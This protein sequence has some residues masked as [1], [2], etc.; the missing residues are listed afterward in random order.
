MHTIADIVVSESATRSMLVV[1]PNV[2]ILNLMRWD[3]DYRAAINAASMRLNDSKVVRRIARFFQLDLP[4][5][6]GSDLTEVLLEKMR[7][8]EHK[9]VVVGS[10]PK[11]IDT[12][13][14][15][16]N[17]VLEGIHPPMRLAQN[18]ERRQ[19]LVSTLSTLEAHVILF[20][21]GSP[22]GE[23]VARDVFAVRTLPGTLIG[24]G[25]SIDFLSGTQRRAPMWFRDNSLE[26]LYRMLTNPGRLGPRYIT[27]F[28]GLLAMLVSEL[29]QRARAR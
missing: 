20:C 10:S 14:A 19:E 27:D 7:G 8:S 24:V 9:V 6:H 23:K 11:D 2:R 21:L 25:A 5:V 12:V 18:E 17:V 15:R 3:A 29:K 22:L 13:R 26:W 16:Y 28:F 4:V 1:T